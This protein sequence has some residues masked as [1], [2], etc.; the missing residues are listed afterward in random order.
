MPSK[1][2]VINL[3]DVLREDEAINADADQTIKNA[4]NKNGKYIEVK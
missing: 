4:S 3:E 1:W 2:E